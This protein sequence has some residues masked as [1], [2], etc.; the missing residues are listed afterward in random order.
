MLQEHNFVWNYNEF[1]FYR[2]YL[3]LESYK[4]VNNHLEIPSK[5]VIPNSEM[6][7]KIVRG[8]KLGFLAEKLRNDDKKFVEYRSMLDKLG[9]DFSKYREVI[10]P[11]RALEAIKVFFISH[12]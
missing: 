6:W 1:C 7:P 9:F 4:K 10:S 8:Y 2:L 5:F 11:E 3:A 12:T